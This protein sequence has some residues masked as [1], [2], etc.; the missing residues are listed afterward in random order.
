MKIGLDG[1]SLIQ[2]KSGIGS[3]AA[4]L[5]PIL[6]DEATRRGH[7]IM[8]YR[9]RGVKDLNTVRRILW[10]SFQL[11]RKAESD[12]VDILYS[13]GFSPPPWGN[14][15]KVVTV[16]DLIGLI[17]PGNVGVAACF[18]W[19]WWLPRN[20]RHADKR[21][22]SSEST[23]RDIEKLLKI[24]AAST[25]VV[26]LGANI[27]FSLEKKDLIDSQKVLDGYGLKS[28]YILSVGTLEPRKNSL[29]LVN[30][31]KLIAKEIEPA[32]LVFVG[33]D[34]G[35]ESV[36]RDFIQ[37]NGLTDRVRILGYVPDAELRHLYGR[38]LGYAMIS[39]YEG[40]GLPAL[41]AMSNGLAGVVS[42]VSSLPEVVGDAAWL[43]DPKNTDEISQALK[44]LVLD[45]KKRNYLSV[46]ALERSKEPQFNLKTTAKSMV[47]IFERE[48]A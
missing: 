20:I 39:L 23:R 7:E 6:M 13:P 34:G 11:P 42:R 16:H 5:L 32:N 14:F 44:S 27:L 41:E 10:E 40:F 19:S 31:F 15:K 47:D 33:K 45:E 35:V 22:A 1:S 48:V 18:Y 46:M 9:P 26:L 30:A 24:P 21:V 8:V 4:S 17:Y 29:G 36:L 37:K 38:A 2:K 25:E 43:V 28:P 12:K 3:F